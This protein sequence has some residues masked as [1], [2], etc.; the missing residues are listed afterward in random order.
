MDQIKERYPF[1]VFIETAF[2]R[3]YEAVMGKNPATMNQ[4]IETYKNDE[5]LSAFAESIHRNIVPIKF[6]ITFKES[7]GFVEGNNNK[8]EL[9]PHILYGRSGLFNLA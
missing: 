6:G 8:F 9:I 4:F 3:F 2:S 7:S 5:H 1:C